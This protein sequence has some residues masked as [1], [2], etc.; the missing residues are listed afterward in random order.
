MTVVAL[1]HKD[2]SLLEDKINNLYKATVAQPQIKCEEKHHFGPNIYIKE[3]TMPA[4]A[5]IIGKHHRMEHLCNMVS[6]RMMI[7]QEDGSTKELIAPMT[8]MAKP[9]RKVAYILETVVFQNIY[10]TPETDIQKLE[11]MCIDNS[12][13]LLEGGN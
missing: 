9:G 8:F 2:P 4:G 1:K 10:S 6:G 13:T 11:D 7:L 12:K 3:V 5:L